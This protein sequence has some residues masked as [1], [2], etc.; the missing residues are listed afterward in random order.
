MAPVG[1]IE[2]GVTDD[3]DALVIAMCTFPDEMD[4]GRLAHWMEQ[5]WQQRLRFPCWEAHATLVDDDQVEFLGATRVS[6]NGHY[7]TLHVVAQR[8]TIP[9]QRTP[10]E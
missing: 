6:A 4:A 10:A 3:A 7:V 1:R 2:V 9:T 8:A 5:L